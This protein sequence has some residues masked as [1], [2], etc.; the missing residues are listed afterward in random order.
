MPVLNTFRHTMLARQC[1]LCGLPEQTE[2]C[3]ETNFK[4]P[5]ACYMAVWCRCRCV[6]LFNYDVLKVMAC[7]KRCGSFLQGAGEAG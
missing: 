7:H 5:D 1:L 3:A 6:M 2:R 4:Q